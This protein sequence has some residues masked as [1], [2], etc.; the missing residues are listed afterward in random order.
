MEAEV[1]LVQL[2]SNKTLLAMLIANTAMVMSCKHKDPYEIMGPM[3]SA[4]ARWGTAGVY[5]CLD[6]GSAKISGEWSEP[7]YLKTLRTLVKE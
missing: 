2:T 5:L 7:S 1:L 3:H 4:V 6:C